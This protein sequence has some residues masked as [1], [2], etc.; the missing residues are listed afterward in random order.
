[1]PYKNSVLV[2]L[3]LTFSILAAKSSKLVLM[4]SAVHLSDKRKSKKSERYW[5]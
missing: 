4:F 1:M 3:L 2:L 5:V